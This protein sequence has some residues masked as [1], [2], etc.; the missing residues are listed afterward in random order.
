LG[1]E[2]DFSVWDVGAHQVYLIKKYSFLHTVAITLKHIRDADIFPVFSII[3]S[4]M[5][6]ELEK[7]NEESYIF[8]VMTY[9]AKAGKTEY[10][11]EI[12]QVIKELDLANEEEVMGMTLAEYW[13]Q[14]LIEKT[15]Q[16]GHQEGHQ[17][18]TL[19][20]AKAMCEQGIKIPMIASITKLSEKEIKKLLD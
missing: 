15:R 4:Q 20:L 10:P 2:E 1:F 3:I 18:R 14:E 17:Q 16:E 6:K 13:K 8:T 7:R 11:K 9:M 5:L 19:E 12:S